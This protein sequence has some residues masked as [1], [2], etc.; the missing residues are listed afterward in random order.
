MS[1]IVDSGAA[2]TDAPQGATYLRTRGALLWEFGT[3]DTLARWSVEDIEYGAPKK[4]EA[5]V[6]LAASGICHS[7]YHYLTGDSAVD[8]TPLLGGHEGAGVVVEVG[9]DTTGVQV[10][11]HVVTTFMPACGRCTWC[12]IGR[13]NLCDRGAGLQTGKTLDGTHRVH[14][15]DGTPVAQMTYIGTFSPYVVVPAD[16]LIPVDRD[17]PLDK[18]A[19]LGCGV[20]TGWGSAVNVADVRVGDTV[21]VVGIGGV[22]MNAVQGARHAG[23]SNI[24]VVDPVEWK[25]KA[26]ISTFGATHEAADLAEADQIV[27]ELTRGVG[28]DRTIMV[29]GVADPN[30]LQTLLNLTSKG[31]VLA[32][33]NVTAPTQLDAQLNIRNLVLLEKQIRGGMYG[34]CNPRVDIPRLVALYKSGQ[35]L[36]DELVTTTYR[37]DEINQACQDMIDGKNLRG[38]ILFDD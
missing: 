22:G 14:T 18:L 24:V 12:G 21:V 29:M 10:G 4:N 9:P 38:V 27:R 28:A 7:D 31:G 34:S 3:A 5:V 25:R 15:P 19:I 37:L 35:L 20:P 11:D 8:I 16:C 33:T 6:K 17:V 13:S 36:L 32:L 1:V 23:A 30:A 26:A 2:R